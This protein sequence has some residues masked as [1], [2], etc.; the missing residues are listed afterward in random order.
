[1][2]IHSFIPSSAVNG[3][4]DRTVVWFQGCLLKCEGCWNQD[5]HSFNHGTETTPANL[6]DR[7]LSTGTAGVTFSG[8]EPLHQMAALAS[9]IMLLKRQE[10]DFSIGMY[11]GYSLREV[12]R[13]EIFHPK[14]VQ[15]HRAGKWPR[16]MNCRWWERIRCQLDFAVM[17]RYNQQ[18]PSD[19]P[20]RSSRNQTLELFNGKFTE[21]DF[22]PQLTEFNISADMIQITGFPK[23]E[24]YENA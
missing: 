15:S 12:I 16:D 1:M 18:Q 4:G 22:G 19:L 9:V 14:S 17:G 10:P 20:L 24:I 11:T 23:R 2:I 6:A 7:I 8:G 3:P 21:D 13:G 5:T